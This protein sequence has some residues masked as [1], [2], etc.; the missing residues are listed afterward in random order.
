MWA[1]DE[2]SDIIALAAARWPDAPTASSD[3]VWA[4][5]RKSLERSF[6]YEDVM[7]ALILL[8][9]NRDRFPPLARLIAACQFRKDERLKAETP[10]LPAPK[11][12]P[13]VARRLAAF[14]QGA[15]DTRSRLHAE[16]AVFARKYPMDDMDKRH[17]AI[18][19]TGPWETKAR[20]LLERGVPSG[21]G[22]RA[23]VET[24]IET[25]SM[26]RRRQVREEAAP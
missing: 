2:F 23:M 22:A 25:L 8:S 1:S 3:A 6:T 17:A 19:A 26:P 4:E 9:E 16:L 18:Q 13:S 15:L 11:S 20:E 21:Q 10:K 24:F 14:D 5:W 12:E 7:E